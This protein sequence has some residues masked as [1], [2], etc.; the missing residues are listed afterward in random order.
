MRK[1]LPFGVGD[2]AAQVMAAL[3]NVLDETPNTIHGLRRNLADPLD[4]WVGKDGQE[5]PIRAELL[6]P[7]KETTLQRSGVVVERARET[8]STFEAQVQAPVQQVIAQRRQLREQIIAYRQ[9]N[10]I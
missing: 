4:S 3:T 6:R 9:A 5:A 7:L 2:R 8:G 1:W 10:E